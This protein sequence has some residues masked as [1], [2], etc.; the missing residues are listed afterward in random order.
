MVQVVIVPILYKD[1]ETQTIIQKCEAFRADLTAAGIR[2]KLDDRDNYTPGWK[3]NDWEVK[4]VCIRMEVG[5]AD[6]KNETVRLVR[7]DTNEKSNVGWADVGKAVPVML[8]SIHDSMLRKA[9]ENLDKSIVKVSVA[10]GRYSRWLVLLLDGPSRMSL[11]CV[12]LKIC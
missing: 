8:D 7:R 3:F 2:V 11:V 5:P 1:A 9:K 10:G 4:G 12:G 6:M